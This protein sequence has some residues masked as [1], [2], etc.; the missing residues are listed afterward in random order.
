[1]YTANDINVLNNLPLCDLYQ[2]F[3]DV[4]AEM[5]RRDGDDD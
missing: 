4:N 1:M 2:L 3:E 5:S